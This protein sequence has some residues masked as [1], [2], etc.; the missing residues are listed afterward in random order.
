MLFFA[1]LCG[2]LRNFSLFFP[3]FGWL[4]NDFFLFVSLPGGSF[5]IFIFLQHYLL[6]GI[7]RVSPSFCF[8]TVTASGFDPR[9]ISGFLFIYLFV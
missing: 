6:P 3:L 7:F 1:F 2:F 4:K 9:L 8:S 5:F